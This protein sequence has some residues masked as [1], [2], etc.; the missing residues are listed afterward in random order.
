MQD[1]HLKLSLCGA[2]CFDVMSRLVIA[3]KETKQG[4]SCA[5]EVVSHL[6]EHIGD[7]RALVYVQTTEM[8]RT[9]AGE[10]QQVRV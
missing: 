2:F 1:S 7:G 5:D 9:L 8:A 10:L 4:G 3:Q 6:S